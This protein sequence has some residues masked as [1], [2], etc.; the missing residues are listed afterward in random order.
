V[1]VKVFDLPEAI[2]YWDQRH[3]EADVLRSGGDMSFDFAGN[4]MFYALRTGRLIDLIGDAS[5]VTAPKRLLDAG[6]GK[7]YFSHQMAA[8]GHVVDGIDSS[9]HAIELCRSAA[10]ER[11]NYAVSTL[12]AW[13]PPY[14]YD[15]VYCVD[16]LFHIMDNEVWEASVR[17][18]ASLVAWGGRLLLVDHGG[19]QDRLWSRYQ[20]TRAGSR[21]DEVLTSCGFERDGFLV[22]GFRA[23]PAGFHIFTRVA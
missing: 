16:V 5:S 4:Q 22:Y 6:C 7:G 1:V 18:L 12:D 13:R 10:T 23:T 17:N 9:E 3:R 11:E 20:R 19:P 8:F 15:V 21:Y 2:D 14:L